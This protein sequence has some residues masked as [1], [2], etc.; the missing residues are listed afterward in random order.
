MS[1]HFASRLPVGAVVTVLI[2]RGVTGKLKVV[3]LDGRKQYEI[4]GRVYPTV[5]RAQEAEMGRRLTGFTDQWLGLL[6]EHILS[7]VDDP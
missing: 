5:W 4:N 2:R 7:P 6:P 3:W 1:T